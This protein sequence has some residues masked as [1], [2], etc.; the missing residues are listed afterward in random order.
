MSNLP[1][2]VGSTIGFGLW[3]VN[4]VSMEG[5]AMRPN[6]EGNQEFVPENIVDYLKLPFNPEKV[7]VAWPTGTGI[8][9]VDRL[10]LLSLNWLVMTGVGAGTALIFTKF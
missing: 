5:V 7:G 8:N 2:L 9:T 4:V 10:K 6:Q 1:I 3:L